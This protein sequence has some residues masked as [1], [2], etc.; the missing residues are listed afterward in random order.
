MLR[1]QIDAGS[2]STASV[3]RPSGTGTRCS[4]DSN[5]DA[6]STLSVT[7]APIRPSV[8]AAVPASWLVRR[9]TRSGRRR[10]KPVSLGP[11]SLVA[12]GDPDACL[13]A[14]ARARRRSA[15]TRADVAM[16]TSARR[17][18]C[19]DL[20]DLEGS[21]EALPEVEYAP[22]ALDRTGGVK[23]EPGRYVVARVV[24]R[25]EL[26]ELVSVDPVE[27]D[28]VPTAIVSSLV[29]SGDSAPP[30]PESAGQPA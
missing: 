1:A 7:A 28:A 15:R 30:F 26:V 8:R 17:C 16:H 13:W 11:R 5:L 9:Q 3:P 23:D 21:A 20:G 2:A 14:K 27:L 24:R 6:P 12:G 18:R 10:Q 25:F 29:G 22:A 4:G 19:P